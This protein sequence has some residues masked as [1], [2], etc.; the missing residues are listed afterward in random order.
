MEQ[1]MEQLIK[2]E[3]EVADVQHEYWKKM[4]QLADI[5]ITYWTNKLYN[6]EK[7]LHKD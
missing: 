7:T 5:K 3:Q 1:Q 6:Q 4:L 2:T